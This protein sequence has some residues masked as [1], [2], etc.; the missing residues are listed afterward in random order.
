MANIPATP[1][2]RLRPKNTKTDDRLRCILVLII[3][4][5]GIGI[6]VLIARDC[7][8]GV[9][10]VVYLKG[11]ILWLSWLVEVTSMIL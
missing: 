9:V 4:G 3:C 5:T 10:D 11:L 7:E 6:R 1:E 8:E 2:R